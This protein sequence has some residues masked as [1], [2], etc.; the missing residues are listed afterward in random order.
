M[1]IIKAPSRK[2]LEK[3]LP[4]HELVRAFERLFENVSELSQSD[5]I[6]LLALIAENNVVSN[7]GLYNPLPNNSK[8]FIEWDTNAPFY[9]Q[10]GAMG[11]SSDENTLSLTHNGFSQYFGQSQ[12]IQVY[13][14]TGAIIPKSY[15]VCFDGAYNGDVKVKKFI[16]DGTIDGLLVIGIA[17]DDIADGKVGKVLMMGKIE[18]LDTTGSLFGETWALGDILYASQTTAG[19]LTNVRPTSPNLVVPVAVVSEESALGKLQVR[20]ISSS[21]LKYGSFSDTTDQTAAATNTAYPITFNTTI[22]S[23][24]V[25]IGSPTS[26]IYIEESGL[27]SVS[28][29][30]QISSADA[31]KKTLWFF[32]RVNGTDVSTSSIKIS[33]GADTKIISREMTFNFNAGDYMEAV[34][35]TSDVDVKLDPLAATAFAPASPSVILNVKQ[36]AK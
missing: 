30:A 25:S 24:G 26:R 19:Y 34:W 33:M 3:F 10:D 8:D 22:S 31:T 9:K 6:T 13:N 23:N 2:Q 4:N 14:D 12:Y 11:W 20:V 28:F 17:A 32:P 36:I 7:S 16:A 1:A 21:D 29:S 15:I 18:D 35:A 27:Y 5:V